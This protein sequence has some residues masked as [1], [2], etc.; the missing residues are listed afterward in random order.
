MHHSTLYSVGQTQCST[1]HRQDSHPWHQ[2]ISDSNTMYHKNRR[3]KCACNSWCQAVEPS[4]GMH[5]D[6]MSSAGCDDVAWA[7]LNSR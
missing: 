7:G 4:N 3:E 1:D 2:P 6:T 5:A